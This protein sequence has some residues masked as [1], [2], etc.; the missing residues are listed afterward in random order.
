VRVVRTPDARVV[1]DPTGRLAGRGAYLCRDASCFDTATRKR[2]IEHALGVP[3]PAELAAQLAMG[4]DDLAAA[5]INAEPA[6]ATSPRSDTAP[7]T[8]PRGGAHGQK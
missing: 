7:E 4:P 2:A 8:M 1:L 6:Q 3:V 5:P